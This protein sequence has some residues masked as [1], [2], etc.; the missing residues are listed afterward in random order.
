LLAGVVADPGESLGGGDPDGL[1]AVLERRVERLAGDRIAQRRGPDQDLQ[2]GVGIVAGG[3][4]EA[5]ERADRVAI[6]GPRL[7]NRRG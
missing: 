3:R 2:A 4:G 6:A 1:V 7:H 5:L